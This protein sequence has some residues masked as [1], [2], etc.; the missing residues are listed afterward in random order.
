MD[1]RKPTRT[2]L[3][4]TDVCK[5]CSTDDIQKTASKRRPQLGHTS[6]FSKVISL[7]SGT[8]ISVAQFSRE[9]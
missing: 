8:H 3:K 2:C 7:T 9:L 6:A 4:M 5:K 1:E